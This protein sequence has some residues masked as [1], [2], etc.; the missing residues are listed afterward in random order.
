MGL[1]GRGCDGFFKGNFCF[2][3]LQNIMVK[4]TEVFDQIVK[5][6]TNQKNKESLKKIGK[7][8]AAVGLG[9]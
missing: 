3:D 7:V 9:L 4:T 6:A 2:N 8:A 5:E 1:D